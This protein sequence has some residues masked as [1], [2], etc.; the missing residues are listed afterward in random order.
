MP[1]PDPGLPITFAM[2]GRDY[3]IRFPLRILK[4]MNAEA[5]LSILRGGMMERFYQDPGVLAIVVYYGMLTD[6][7][8]VTLEFVE[9]NIEIY[10][11]KDLAPVVAYAMTGKTP[12]QMKE[13]SPN[14]TAVATETAAEPAIGSPYG[15][16]DDTILVSANGISGT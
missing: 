8:D 6:Q 4:R 11:L 16:S 2:A 15:L 12:E 10:M 13:A 1:I 14:V 7:P 5:G 9:D 3:R